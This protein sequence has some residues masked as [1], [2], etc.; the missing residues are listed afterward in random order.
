M[1]VD[2]YRLNSALIEESDDADEI[3]SY[4]I[5]SEFYEGSY[6]LRDDLIG[7]FD[8]FEGLGYILPKDIIVDWYCESCIM[9][10]KNDCDRE[11]LFRFQ[12]N[13]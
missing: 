9:I 10:L 13:H 12:I 5:F 3:G 2:L 11:P 1:L 8:I 7:I 6:V 4:D